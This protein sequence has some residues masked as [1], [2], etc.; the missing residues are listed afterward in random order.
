M[1]VFDTNKGRRV[2]NVGGCAT[3]LAAMRIAARVPWVAQAHSI[4]LAE[5]KPTLIGQGAHHGRQ[6]LSM[7]AASSTID[8]SFGSDVC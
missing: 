8:R 1:I 6:F 5:L 2:L 3:E 7:A 4:L